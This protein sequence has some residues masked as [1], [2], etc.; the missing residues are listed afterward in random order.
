MKKRVITFLIVLSLFLV[1]L[2]SAVPCDLD[3]SL[4]N[5]DPSSAIPGE[6]VRVVFQIN[7]IENPECKPFQFEVKEDFPF[8]L[9]PGTTNPITI[10]PG[11]YSRKYSSFYI[12]PYQ[13]RINEDA[14]NGNNPIEASYTLNSAEILKEF[15]IYIEDV[16]ADFEV[17]VKDYDYTTKELTIE[18]LNTA[19]VDV[20]ALTIEIPKQEN[21][22]D[23]GANRIVVGDLDSNEYTTAD[24]EA[25]LSEG[26][27]QINL[28]IIYTD[29]INTRRSLEKTLI[30]DSSYFTERNGDTKKKP[31]WL[32]I[33]IIVVVLWFVWRSIR[34]AKKK[35][36][37]LKRLHKH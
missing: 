7:G 18:I 25:I 27:N 21:I 33:I 16:R 3:I 26:E 6:Y 30:F 14:L 4:I 2:I 19:E 1:P 28:N 35:K 11:T 37:K 31:V 17:Y 5:Q 15:N 32:Y 36:E 13:I 10:N 20:E 29:T 9:D 24:F 8:S 34:K 12:A 22:K 23:K